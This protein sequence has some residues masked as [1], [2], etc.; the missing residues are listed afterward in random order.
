MKDFRKLK[1]LLETCEWEYA[2]LF[3]YEIDIQNCKATLIF[4][5]PFDYWWLRKYGNK[6]VK[7]FQ[8]LENS[9][10]KE[11]RLIEVQIEETIIRDDTLL[12]DFGCINNDAHL[13]LETLRLDKKP[14]RV[15]DEVVL[16]MQCEGFSLKLEG[17]LLGWSEI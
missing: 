14:S 9:L 10:W 3:K 5:I 6:W 8:F 11:S 1:S 13:E 12:K 7:R 4:D 15:V 17:K 16:S 2:E